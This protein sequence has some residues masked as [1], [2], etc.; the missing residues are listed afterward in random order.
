MQASNNPIAN[1]PDIRLLIQRALL[2]FKQLSRQIRSEYYNGQKLTNLSLYVLLCMRKNKPLLRYDIMKQLHVNY[3]DAGDALESLVLG[4][5][6]GAERCV[7]P[8]NFKKVAV[9]LIRYRL[10]LQGEIYVDELLNKVL[11]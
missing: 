10:T 7:Q 5:L 4:G 11:V 1:S 3:Y 2:D 8:S 9:E 6:V